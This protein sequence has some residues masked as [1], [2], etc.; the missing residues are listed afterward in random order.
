MDNDRSDVE[1]QGEATSDGGGNGGSIPGTGRYTS[2]EADDG[3]RIK[4]FLSWKNLRLTVDGERY[5]L[6]DLSGCAEP[7]R[8]TAI[9]GPSGS[10]K[11]TLL[12]T[13][14]GIYCSICHT[15]P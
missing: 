11:S 3:K 10:G 5:I 1:A 9:M 7:G 15:A 14:S 6:Q 8:L 4:A 12:D 2:E 13:L